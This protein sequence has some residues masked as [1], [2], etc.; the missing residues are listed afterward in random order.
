[1][2]KEYKYLSGMKGALDLTSFLC[3]R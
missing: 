1:M 3:H 2:I